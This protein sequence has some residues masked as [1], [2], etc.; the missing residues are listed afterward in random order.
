MRKFPFL[1]SVFFAALLLCLGF[2][3]AAQEE[4]ALEDIELTFEQRLTGLQK[5]LK[6]KEREKVELKQ[7]LKAEEDLVTQEQ[8][9]QELTSVEDIIVGIREDIVNIST[10]GAELFSEP[11]VVKKK[12]DWKRDL[13]LIFEPL[14]EQLRDISE[15]PRLI[16][17]LEAEI[18]YW[19]E[20]EQELNQAVQN[21]EANLEQ[22]SKNVLKREVKELLGTATSRRNTAQQ[23]L[24]LLRN[25][26]IELR[27]ADNPIWETLRDIFANVIVVLVL[28][29]FVAIGASFL[30]YQIVRLFSFIPIML[31]RKNNSTKTVFAERI[32]IVVRSVVS[33]VLTMMTYFVVLYSFGEW[34]LLVFS[35]LIIAGLMLAMKDT[36]PKYFIELKTLLNMGSIRQGERIVYQGLP[37]RINRL[38]VHTRLYN[39]ALQGHLRVPLTEIV[40]HS[41]R[42]YRHDEPWFPT[43]IGD[44]VFLEDG[45]FGDVLRQTPEIVEVGFGGSI[46]TYQTADFLA[47]RP[48]NLSREGFTVYEIFGFDYQHQAEMTTTMLETYQK[49]I[50][51]AIKASKYKEFNTYLGVEFDNASASS[52]DYKIMASFTGEV[53]IEYFMI[54]RLLQKASVEVANKHGWVIPFQQL[55]VHHQPAEQ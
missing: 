55:T 20:R 37:W 53:A 49:A 46:Y 38:N 22:L 50:E 4:D 35:L 17:K 42:L 14:L 27:E 12:F 54:K 51:A 16:E 8:L 11:P 3:V 24:A 2:S 7:K 34:L 23:K 6:E 5:T 36:V 44:V 48:R 15:R 43:R 9:R 40:N 32:I 13:E 19:E 25:D 41:S 1:I 18:A 28:H 21:L 26:L 10:G 39:S 45:V 33:V 30:V 52:L 47:R 31:I 29:F